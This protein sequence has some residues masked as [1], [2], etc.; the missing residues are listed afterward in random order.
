MKQQI[1]FAIMFILMLSTVSAA[2]VHGTIYDLSLNKIKNIIV[3]VNSVPEQKVVSTDGT[4]SFDLPKGE[5]NITAKTINNKEI[6]QE[7]IEIKEEGTFNIDLF[8]FPELED[9]ELAEILDL[10]IEAID[11]KENQVQVYIL[12]G[13]GLIFIISFI[14]YFSKRLKSKIKKE[15]GREESEKE[16]QVKIKELPDKV[17]EIIKNSDG[18]ITQKELRKKFPFSEAKISLV[19]SELEAKGK[20]EKIKKG[21]GNILILKS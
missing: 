7:S 16:A 13:I 3:E 20:I 21:R 11:L 19:I 14:F 2:T 12:V 5:Y 9:K 15:P 18:R 17:L 4:Y 6:V 1:L 10:D 8:V